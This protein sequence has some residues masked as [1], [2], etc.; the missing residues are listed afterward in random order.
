MQ[1]I[2]M[3]RANWIGVGP[4]GGE[5][6]GVVLY[7]PA[8]WPELAAGIAYPVPNPV[9]GWRATRRLCPG[10][11]GYAI[12][13][14]MSRTTTLI[15]SIQRFTGVSISVTGVSGVCA[16]LWSGWRVGRVCRCRPG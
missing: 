16:S 12:G 14:P 13:S 3:R 10:L 9:R 7:R 11:A 1:W 4:D 2:V 15:T 8:G 5:Q 6:C